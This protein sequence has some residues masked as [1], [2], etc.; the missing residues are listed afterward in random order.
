MVYR[1]EVLAR[2]QRVDNGR[3]VARAGEHR[4]DIRADDHARDLVVVA[5]EHVKV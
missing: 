2:S 4:V 5:V 1:S 3:A